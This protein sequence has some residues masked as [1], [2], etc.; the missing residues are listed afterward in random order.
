MISGL[1]DRI[2]GF[3]RWITANRYVRALEAEVERLRAENRALMNSILGIAG[4]PPV[5]VPPSSA[6]TSPASSQSVAA[7][8]SNAT[9]TDN[10]QAVTPLR[11]RSWQ[12]IN[13]TLEI[14]SARKKD[15]SA[16]TQK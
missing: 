4:I 13:R 10:N 6:S 15:P 1:F 12:Q 14:E 2:R 8:A 7:T 16:E 9:A 3:W 5:V 11:R